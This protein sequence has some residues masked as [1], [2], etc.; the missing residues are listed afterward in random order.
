[1]V[2]RLTTMSQERF[3]KYWL[4]LL[5]IFFAPPLVVAARE[6]IPF[7]FGWKFRP[8]SR[9]DWAPPSN[10]DSPIPP[11]HTT[12]RPPNEARVDYNDSDWWNVQL[13]HDAL[14]GNAP[15]QSACPNG[16]SGHSYIPRH[17]LWYR[18]RFSLPT[19]WLS[20]D[21]HYSTI[22]L[23]FDGSFRNTTVWFDGQWMLNHDCGYTP[24]RVDLPRNA[25]HQSSA[26]DNQH[27]L[28]VFIDPHGT[29]WWY[30]GGGLYRHVR[31]VI[32]THPVHV[33]PNGLF[34]TS[35][36]PSEFRNGQT[37]TAVLVMQASVVVSEVEFT[38][39]RTI[40][41]SFQVRDSSGRPIASTP[42]A[43]L[44]VLSLRE[45]G[46]GRSS[47][48][49]PTVTFE[50]RVTIQNPRMWTAAEPHLYQV[51]VI[52]TVCPVR[53]TN[54]A[55]KEFDRSSV[56][57]GIRKLLFDANRGFF[58]NDQAF[59]IRGF[60]DHDTF[61]VVGMAVPDRINLFRV[62][63]PF[64][65]FIVSNHT[66]YGSLSILFCFAHLFRCSH[67]L[68]VCRHKRLEALGAMDA[69]PPTIHPIQRCWT[70]TIDW[71]WW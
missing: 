1:M 18:K 34:V 24:F 38:N 17:L 67:A 11:H 13:P 60:C 2:L 49:S 25:L 23:E 58:L 56:S 29:G 7:D 37:S 44:P 6:S 64:L 31:M 61:A 4:L 21:D 14:I 57:H 32:T 62:R 41:F 16:C 53:P 28:A 55:N 33:L 10:D 47:S 36:F 40:C 69:A 12:D 54:S 70:F 45:G 63:N 39:N 68:C 42:T 71:G 5:L 65:V 26:N 19:Q 27:V 35:E 52:L 3:Y 66:P 51:D 15:S 43:A 20:T 30:E 48:S 8:G 59:K 50:E 22:S 9:T 46:G